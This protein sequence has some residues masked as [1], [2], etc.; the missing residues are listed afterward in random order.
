MPLCEVIGIVAQVPVLESHRGGGQIE[1]LDLITV[2]VEYLGAAPEE[3]EEGVNGRIEEAIQGLDGVKRVTSNASEGMGTVS[4]ELLLG[5]D[6]RKVIIHIG[7]PVSG[8]SSGGGFTV[9]LGA[10]L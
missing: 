9:E 7:Q 2:S 1:K 3:V 5:A 8:R 10:D 6:S 4:V